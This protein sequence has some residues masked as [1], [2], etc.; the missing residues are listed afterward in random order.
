MPKKENTRVQDTLPN[1]RTAMCINLFMFS[2]CGEQWRV[3][4]AKKTRYAF[5]KGAGLL[6]KGTGQVECREG[7]A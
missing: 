2:F 3:L 5:E 6:N 7:L 4:G 1:G